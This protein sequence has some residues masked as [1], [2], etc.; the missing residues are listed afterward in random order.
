MQQ[1][2]ELQSF[3]RAVYTPE[4]S[5]TNTYAISTWTPFTPPMSDEHSSMNQSAGLLSQHE[6]SE[7]VGEALEDVDIFEERPPLV[8]KKAMCG[9][10][11]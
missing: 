11:S 8:S 10:V 3:R 1:D 4:V 5:A 6:S 2:I 7:F 9:L